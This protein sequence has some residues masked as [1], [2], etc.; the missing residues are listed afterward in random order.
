MSDAPGQI[1]WSQGVP[2][3]AGPYFLGL[4]QPSP[5]TKDFWDGVARRELRLKWCAP[6]ARVHH[7]KRIVCTFCGNTELASKRAAGRGTVY[8]FSE[9]HRAAVAAFA[10]ATPYT[11]GVVKLDEGVHLF[12]RF[13]PS[14]GP[15][16]IDD[17]VQVDFRVLEMGQLLPVFVVRE[18]S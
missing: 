15:I 10:S 16:A 5:E 8:S 3:M 14:A 4:Y 6:C 18:R 2:L 11:V 17:P 1:D 13:I 9:V 7:P 12:T